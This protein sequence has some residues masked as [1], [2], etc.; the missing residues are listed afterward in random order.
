[1]GDIVAAYDAILVVKTRIGR[2][3]GKILVVL[4]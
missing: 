4:V 2:Q 3:A 1:M